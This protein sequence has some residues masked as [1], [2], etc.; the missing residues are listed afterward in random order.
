M[1]LHKEMN[2]NKE[3]VNMLIR[4]STNTI[5]NLFSKYENSKF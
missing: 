3:E 2:C 4:D 1:E 5:E